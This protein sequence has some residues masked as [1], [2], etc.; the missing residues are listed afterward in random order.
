MSNLPK[1]EVP[2]L[3][4]IENY[5]TWSIRAY[6]LLIKEDLGFDT[7]DPDGTISDETNITPAKNRKALAIIKLLC[8]DNPLLY[9]KD[10]TSAIQAWNTLKE[11]FNPKGFTT[12]FLVLKE[13]F[14]TTLGD[15][16]TME[17]YLNKVKLLI[18]DLKSKDIILPNQVVIA[19]ILNSLDEDYSGFIQ[20]ITQSLRNDPKAYTIDSLIKSLIDE[21]RGKDDNAIYS[22]NNSFYK[23]NNKN[24]KISKNNKQNKQNKK[25]W[26]KQ[27]L[28]GKFCKNCHKTNHNV[29][30]CYFLYPKKRPDW[31][32]SNDTDDTDDTNNTNNINQTNKKQ[33]K[34]QDI[35]IVNAI[36][37]DSDDLDTIPIQDIDME[38]DNLLL[39]LDNDVSVNNTPKK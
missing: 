22:I 12:E 23:Q 15:F 13:F 6:A 17:Q 39:D 26:K 2:K 7:L 29:D 20:N 25:P 27:P 21:S 36:L 37:S 30:D 16:D 3:L 18:N 31:W 5:T 35:A 9:I 19:W 14:N 33:Q 8:D 24:N 1:I 28:S 11:L 34:Q 38:I 32:K 4:G 10:E